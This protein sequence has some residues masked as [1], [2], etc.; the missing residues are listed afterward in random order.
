VIPIA[1]PRDTISRPNSLPAPVAEPAVGS[2]DPEHDPHHISVTGL[3]FSMLVG[4]ALVPFAIP[5]LWYAAPFVT[6][7]D[8]ALSMAVP[9]SLAVA[10]AALCLGVVYTID[11]GGTTRVKGVLMLVAL[12]YASAAGLYFLKKDLVDRVQRVLGDSNRWSEVSLD[13]G[14]CQ[15]RMPGRVNEEKRQPLEGLA[16]FAEGRRAQFVVDAQDGPRYEYYFAVGKL[17][18]EAVKVDALW[19]DR[20]RDK[21]QKEG[22]TL[23]GEPEV[24]G[25]QGEKDVGR[26]WTFRLADN[27]VRI[28][29]VFAIKERIYYL[30]AEG[31]SLTADDK[32]YAEPFFSTFLVK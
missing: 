26:Q 11:W 23:V 17:R 21:L 2:R 1:P 13:R 8:P 4:M 18:P 5:L 29:Q 3:P 6:G 14:G 28:V 12:S 7:Q 27:S 31:P 32:E 24:L 25:H 22:S 30:A 15:I 9:V 10:A 19:F 20:V 16:R